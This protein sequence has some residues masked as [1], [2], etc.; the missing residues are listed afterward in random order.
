M[1]LN[2]TSATGYPLDWFQAQ[3]PLTFGFRRTIIPRKS[4]SKRLRVRYWIAKRTGFVQQP[5]AG[6]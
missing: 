1:S 3:A 5:T 2:R 6:A 4:N